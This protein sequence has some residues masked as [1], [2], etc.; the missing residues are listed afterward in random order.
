MTSSPA[1]AAL[2]RHRFITATALAVAV[3]VV[4][5]ALALLLW[6]TGSSKHHGWPSPNGDLAGTR[7]ASGS[8]IDA[9]NV[10]R[11]RPAWRFA[12]TGYQT[13]SGVFAS[14][15]VVLD[16]HVYLQDLD[17]DVFAL[18]AR[19]GRLAWKTHA[20]QVS[21]GPNGLT[22]ADGRVYGSTNRS[23]FALDAA[24]G[25]VVW[26]R[27][28]VLRDNQAIDI[29]PQAAN[30]L[31]YTSTVGLMPGGKGVLYALDAATGAIRWKFDTVLGEWA[32]PSQAAGGGAWWPV[33]I[34]AGGTVYAGTANPVPWGGTPKLP[35]G[36]AYRG[37]DLYTDSLLA[38][39]GKTGKLR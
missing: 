6:P 28:L 1:R 25:K 13:P 10:G 36:G 26:R 39:D 14:T 35:N 23:A 12:L 33:S 3:C 19:T 5:V 4:G 38:L 22:A 15:P 21:G 29:A 34:G 24:T 30:G 18:D 8:S 7:A 20:R 32:V 37:R 16:G 11:L 17:S 27:K 2:A 31:V 9:A